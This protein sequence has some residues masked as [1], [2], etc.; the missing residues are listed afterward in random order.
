M[1]I[2][3]Y[4]AKEINSKL[5]SANNQRKQTLEKIEQVKQTISIEQ[6][7]DYYFGIDLS[8]V[9]GRTS[10]HIPCPFHDEKTASFSVTPS[11][12][13]FQCFGCGRKGDI[14]NLIIELKR[15]SPG[16]AA[17]I[18]AKDFGL[19]DSSDPTV[20]RKIEK[21]IIDKAKMQKFK[22]REKMAFNA[23][24]GFRDILDNFIKEIKTEG[25]L[26]RLGSVYHLKTD[27][28]RLMDLSLETKEIENE[29]RIANYI[30]IRNW[31]V[32]YAYPVLDRLSKGMN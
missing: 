8:A 21:R 13:K 14:L 17:Y 29:D 15:V 23:L 27:V 26:S 32:K 4:K 10:K 25:D 6:V 24:L 7:L 16:R 1:A 30:Y 9:K 20:K 31:I 11:L 12:N 28:N 18:I 19:S 3:N 22:E 2:S 5:T